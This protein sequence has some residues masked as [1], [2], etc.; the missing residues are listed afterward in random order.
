MDTVK[1]S[2]VI[3]TYNHCDDLL[4]PCID[5]VFKNTHMHDIEI[6]VVANGCTDNTRDYINTIDNVSLLWFDEPIGYTRAVNEGIKVSKGEYVLL[7]NNDVQILDY[8]PKNQWLEKL[9]EPFL[10]NDKVA[11]TGTVQ[12]HEPAI[13]KDFLIFFCVLIKRTVFDK[14]GLLD[15]IFSPGYGEDI[16]F[17]IRVTNNN[18]EWICVDQT[19]EKNGM[20]V[21]Y[22]PLYHRGTATFSEMS[23]YNDVVKRNKIILQQRYT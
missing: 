12:Y 7:L 3:P 23:S 13:N 8:W 11:V 16:D 6:I 14:I 2:I 9:T 17:C 10:I 4:K 19:T 1:Y 21:G 15:E 22:F 20:H 5:S 18:L